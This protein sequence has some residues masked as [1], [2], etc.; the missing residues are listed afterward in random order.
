MNPGHKPESVTDSF[1]PGNQLPDPVQRLRSTPQWMKYASARGQEPKLGSSCS[2]N[3]AY[4][5]NL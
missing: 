5:T 2:R 3:T 1:R 4:P